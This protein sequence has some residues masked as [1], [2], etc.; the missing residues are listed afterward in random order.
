MKSKICPIC[1]R[2]NKG[3]ALYCDRCSQTFVVG[4]ASP[5]PATDYSFPDIY[6]LIKAD[7]VTSLKKVIKNPDYMPYVGSGERIIHFAAQFGSVKLVKYLLS[8]DARLNV[9]DSNGYTPLDLAKRYNHPKI[10]EML[11]VKG[12]RF[13]KMGGIDKKG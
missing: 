2:K 12:A 8:K 4:K 10:L 5:V 3:D 13:N 6:E 11:L 9:E 7:D 1:G